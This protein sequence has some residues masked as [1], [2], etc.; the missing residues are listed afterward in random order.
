MNRQV[1]KIN[2]TAIESKLTRQNYL[3]RKNE[4]FFQSRHLMKELSERVL[5]RI[6]FRS[7]SSTRDDL[8][9]SESL[10]VKLDDDWADAWRFL[11]LE[12]VCSSWST[13]WRRFFMLEEWSLRK[14]WSP[15]RIW[16]SWF[17]ENIFFINTAPRRTWKFWRNKHQI[18]S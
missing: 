17:G 12:D 8:T 14:R 5:H 7:G 9:Q 16:R 10:S 15:S 11:R 3:M 2:T 4:I 18:I 6:R 13:P 1:C